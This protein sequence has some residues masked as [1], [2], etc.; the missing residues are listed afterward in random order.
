MSWHALKNSSREFARC[1]SCQRVPGSPD[2]VN[3]EGDDG[4]QSAKDQGQAED[5]SRYLFFQRFLEA[6]LEQ[7]RRRLQRPGAA[8]VREML[9]TPW[10]QE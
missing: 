10:A 9:A 5:Q 4:G 8:A 1:F 3:G 7:E 2:C 6:I